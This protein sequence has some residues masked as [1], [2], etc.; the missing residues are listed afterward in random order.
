M[1]SDENLEDNIIGKTNEKKGRKYSQKKAKL[2]N[3]VGLKKKKSAHHKA[4]N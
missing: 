1:Q 3:V 2:S 4:A